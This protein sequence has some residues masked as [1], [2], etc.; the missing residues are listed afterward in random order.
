MSTFVTENIYMCASLYIQWW[1]HLLAN[2][3]IGCRLHYSGCA[4]CAYS[5]TVLYLQH[6]PY[7]NKQNV[8]STCDIN[9][10]GITVNKMGMYM[11]WLT[12]LYNDIRMIVMTLMILLYV[13][14][15][16]VMFVLVYQPVLFSYDSAKSHPFTTITIFVF[17]INIPVYWYPLFTDLLFIILFTFSL[18][19]VQFFA[20][21]QVFVCLVVYKWPIFILLLLLVCS[22]FSNCFNIC[23]NGSVSACFCI[24]SH[25]YG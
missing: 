15:L 2:V 3:P 12:E 20:G 21:Y 16:Y 5:D 25:R 22:C 19:I 11:N 1:Y 14:W 10:M 8:W 9:N 17:V 4:S 18:S 24:W 7:P 23:S 13:Q 6:P